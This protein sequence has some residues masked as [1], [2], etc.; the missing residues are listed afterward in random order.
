ML[1]FCFA[2]SSELDI[3]NLMQDFI[4]SYLNNK[5]NPDQQH[6]LIGVIQTVLF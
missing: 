1:G 2:R 3:D 5:I 6:D 4:L